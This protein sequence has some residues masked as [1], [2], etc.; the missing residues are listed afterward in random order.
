MSVIKALTPNFRLKLINFD[1]VTWHD[2]MN[3]NFQV[4]DAL[5]K[6][7]FSLPSL[8]GVWSNSL[9]VTLGDTY[10]DPD[11]G[12]LWT[13]L[14]SHTTAASP[15]LFAADRVAN[16]TYWL[17]ATFPVRNRGAY[18]DATYYAIGDIVTSGSNVYINNVSHTSSGAINLTYF[19]LLFAGGG[20]GGTL[21]TIAAPSDA[22]KVIRVNAASDAYEL[23]PAL[24][25]LA[26]LNTIGT[27]LIDDDAVTY[28]KIQNVSAT[29][30]ILGRSTAGAGDIEEITC[31]PFARTL[32][33]DTTQAAMRTTLGLTPGTDVQSFNGKLASISSVIFAANKGL[34]FS[35][36]NTVAAYDLSSFTRTLSASSDANA[37]KTS[38]VIDV[39]E[40]DA[41]PASGTVT[42]DMNLGSARKVS[43]SGNFTLDVTPIT[44]KAGSYIMKLVIGGSV[45]TITWT[46]VDDW[47]GD[48]APT[49]V[50]SHTYLIGFFADSA[51][52]VNAMVLSDMT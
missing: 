46:G 11:D 47:D 25:T 51:G 30:R 36:T 5:M 50:A 52:V 40:A 8:K 28:A 35:G 44:G 22:F 4:I 23:G 17:N 16:P 39:Q 15:T 24:A 13:A 41:A 29:D 48:T 45:P 21:P 37:A 19:S 9:A 32:L 6:K 14:V 18:A 7:Y 12:T 27:A 34:Y 1:V 3:S 49:L 20:G 42:L 43:P 2:E 31:T 33:D 38:L 26:Y 10:T